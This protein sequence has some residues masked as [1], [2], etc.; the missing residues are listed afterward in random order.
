M[1]EPSRTAEHAS[2]VATGVHRCTIHDDRIDFVSESY[3]V[4]DNGRAVLIDA[5]PM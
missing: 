2:E 4:T 5:L 3:V 1:P